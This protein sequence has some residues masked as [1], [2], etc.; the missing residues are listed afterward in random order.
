MRA[1]SGP[2]P[3]SIGTRGAPPRASPSSACSTTS[4]CGVRS[5]GAVHLRPRLSV[6]GRQHTR[7]G[8]T[9]AARERRGPDPA[10]APGPHGRRP[11]HVARR[12]RRRPGARAAA[13][14]ARG[15]EGLGTVRRKAGIPRVAPPAC[16]IR[17]LP[18]RSTRVGM[19]GGSG[20]LAATPVRKPFYR[21]TTIGGPS[22]PPWPARSP[23][24][25]ARTRRGIPSQ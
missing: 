25:V 22:A 2:P 1:L 14:R 17:P 15:G 24:G 9:S 19:S 5:W 6:R 12:P 11:R 23:T 18:A 4:P 7:R 21:T 10:P 3:P 8:A 13:H 20:S 16:A